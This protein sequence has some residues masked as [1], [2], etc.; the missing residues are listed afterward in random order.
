MS[1]VMCAG[2][3]H[4]LAQRV[5]DL[6]GD[7]TKAATLLG[8]SQQAVSSYL[9]GQMMSAPVFRMATA[10][11]ADVLVRKPWIEAWIAHQMKGDGSVEMIVEKWLYAPSG[12][13]SCKERNKHVH[14]AAV[15]ARAGAARITSDHMGWSLIVSGG[16][17]GF[18]RQGTNGLLV[19]R[20]YLNTENAVPALGRNDPLLGDATKGR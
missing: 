10:I 4:E 15:A 13:R 12:T 17:L 20:V 16:I 1:E 6:A 18:Y 5:I 3:S 11:L 9:N 14:L 8:I 7:Q 19:N 2:K